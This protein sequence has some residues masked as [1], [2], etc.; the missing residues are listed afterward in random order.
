MLTVDSYPVSQ[1]L[2]LLINGDTRNIR[3]KEFSQGRFCKVYLKFFDE[4]VDLEA[5]RSFYFGK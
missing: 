3:P 1:I 5:M 4:Q 2:D